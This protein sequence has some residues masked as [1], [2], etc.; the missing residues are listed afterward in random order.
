MGVYLTMMGFLVT[1]LNGL[2]GSTRVTILASVPSLP[3]AVSVVVGLLI[4]QPIS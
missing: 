2:Q 3:L 1:A 4:N